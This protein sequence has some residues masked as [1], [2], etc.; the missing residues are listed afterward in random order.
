MFWN[1][2]VLPPPPPLPI[3]SAAIPQL[4]NSAANKQNQIA[5]PDWK[6]EASRPDS[7]AIYNWL[8]N[9]RKFTQSEIRSSK[10]R[11]EHYSKSL[12]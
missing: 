1:I 4:V 9:H 3:D 7:S 12:I 10:G 11:F 8:F 2:I 5:D 6:Q